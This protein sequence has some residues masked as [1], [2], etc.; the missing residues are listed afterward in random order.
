MKK[1]DNTTIKKY[2]KLIK[3]QKKVIIIT[4]ITMFTITSFFALVFAPPWRVAQ[5]GINDSTEIA[6]LENSYRATIAQIIGGFAI[7]IGLYYTWQRITI[8][9]NNLKI[10]QDNL[11]ISQEGQITERFTRAIDQL[12]NKKMEIRLGG[13]YALERI[14]KESKDDYWAIMEILTAYIR[15]NSPFQKGDTKVEICK[16]TH[17]IKEIEIQD[18]LDIINQIK[19]PLDVETILNIIVERNY[20]FISFRERDAVGLKEGSNFYDSKRYDEISEYVYDFE[21]GRP[22]EPKGLDLQ[23]TYLADVNL[24]GAHLEGALFTGSFLQSA[25]LNKVHLPEANL[26]GAILKRAY[27]IEADLGK[28]FLLGADL[29]RAHIQGADLQEANLRNANLQE[30]DLTNANLQ[31]ADLTDANL[32]EADLRGAQNISI[33][34]LSKVESLYNTKIDYELFITLN[35]KYPTLFEKPEN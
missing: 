28:A 5:F 11:N 13:I 17:H 10:A 22:R 14:S 8:A 6:N 33:D 18:F 3:E 15:I 24:I 27:L 35:E 9:E 7:I 1:E 34:Q 31:E 20:H 16:S 12:G 4:A 32:Q 21:S 2:K 19:V 30:A 23:R 29:E 25:S 26:M